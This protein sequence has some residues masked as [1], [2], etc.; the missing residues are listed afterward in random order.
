MLPDCAF[1]ITIDMAMVSM[2]FLRSDSLRAGYIADV[3][4]SSGNRSKFQSAIYFVKSVSIKFDAD[5]STSKQQ[6]NRLCVRM[7]ECHYITDFT[8]FFIQIGTSKIS[9][10]GVFNSMRFMLLAA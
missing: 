3:C 2:K 10:N 4:I 6:S 9:L 8:V 7:Q 5:S 1:M